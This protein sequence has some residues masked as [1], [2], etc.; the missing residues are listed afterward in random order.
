M[1]AA[2]VHAR[3]V[4]AGGGGQGGGATGGGATG[5]GATGELVL[6][7]GGG[8]G[9]GATGERTSSYHEGYGR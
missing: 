2:A 8:Q 7:A 9:G 1:C 6:P 5:G 3:V 4:C